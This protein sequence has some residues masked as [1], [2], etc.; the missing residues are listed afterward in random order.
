MLQ[1]T[2]CLCRLSRRGF[3]PSLWQP[4]TWSWSE[5]MLRSAATT[6][7]DNKDKKRNPELEVQTKELISDHGHR[8]ANGNLPL[9][10]CGTTSSSLF[11]YSL[12]AN[13]FGSSFCKHILLFSDSCRMSMVGLSLQ[14]EEKRWESSP[15]CR[16][17][18]ALH[19]CR[20]PWFDRD[21]QLQ[22]EARPCKY[23]LL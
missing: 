16:L 2:W 13:S 6:K 19:Q 17:L 7:D 4:C 18:K 21:K 9:S 15:Q 23:F 12:Y 10:N 5:E 8:N 11:L 22:S 1:Q 14:Q 20:P 3:G